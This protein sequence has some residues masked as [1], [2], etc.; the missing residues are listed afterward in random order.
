MERESE[1]WSTR[2]RIAI[3][4]VLRRAHRLEPFRQRER[5]TMI[6]PRGNA[7]TTGGRVPRCLGPLDRGFVSHV[8][9]VGPRCA[10][11]EAV[12]GGPPSASVRRGLVRHA[13]DVV[14]GDLGQAGGPKAAGRYPGRPDTGTVST[15]TDEGPHRPTCGA[16]LSALPD[17]P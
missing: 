15:H 16:I 17:G 10:S 1:A 4:L 3:E 8:P 7:V 9:S 13:L 6:T 12:F 14:E 11:Q 5:V 2:P